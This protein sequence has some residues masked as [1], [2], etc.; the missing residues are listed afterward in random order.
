MIQDRLRLDAEDRSRL[1][2]ALEAALRAGHGRVSV[3]ALDAAG[4]GARVLRYSSDLHCADCDLHYQDATPGLFSF[5]SPLGACDTCRGFGR[6][7]G[8]DYGLVVPD[9]GKSLAGGA[10][11]PW[12]TPSYKECQDDL[13]RYAKKRGIATNVPWRDLTAQRPP[14]G[15]RRRRPM[16]QESLVRRPPLLRWLETKAYKMHIR[17]LLSKYRSYTS[18]RAATARASSPMRCCGAWARRAT[19]ERRAA[20]WRSTS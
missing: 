18:A 13:L 9:D 19:L 14:V 5:N 3:H 7:I 1:V 11:R 20:A 4:D 6:V 17:V 8:I 2:E 10:V 12:Q 15:H 16:E